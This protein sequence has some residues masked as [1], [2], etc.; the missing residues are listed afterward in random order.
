MHEEILDRDI[1]LLVCPKAP[2]QHDAKVSPV[3]SF[4]R[5]IQDEFR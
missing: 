5:L 1:P 2:L 4:L 3:Q